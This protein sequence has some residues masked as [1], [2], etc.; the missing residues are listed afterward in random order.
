MAEEKK[1]GLSDVHDVLAN[2]E[3][4]RNAVVCPRVRPSSFAVE[5]PIVNLIIAS[6]ERPYVQSISHTVQR[7]RVLAELSSFVLFRF[8]LEPD[9]LRW[10]VQVRNVVQENVTQSAYGL[11]VRLS[12]SVRRP[13]FQKQKAESLPV[14]QC[15]KTAEIISSS[16]QLSAG[17]VEED[18]RSGAI[19]ALSPVLATLLSASY[20]GNEGGG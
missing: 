16:G 14:R 8:D 1:T 7:Q 9:C 2:G 3:Q 20:W 18:S 11:A 10:Q 12:A 5:L 4:I 19:V 13:M 6:T 17:R 15:T